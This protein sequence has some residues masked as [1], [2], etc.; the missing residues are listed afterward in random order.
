MEKPWMPGLLDMLQP[1]AKREPASSE[2]DESDEAVSEPAVSSAPDNF[3]DAAR[4]QAE[5]QWTPPTK[6]TVSDRPV[7]SPLSYGSDSGSPSGT[8]AEWARTAKSPLEYEGSTYWN[9]S[10]SDRIIAHA[11]AVTIVVLLAAAL[12]ALSFYYRVQVGQ[13]LVRFGENLSGQPAQQSA[14]ATPS[15]N[16]STVQ[17]ATPP[18]QSA[19]PQQPVSPSPGTSAANPAPTSNAPVADS[20]PSTADADVA[21]K[22]PAGS[23]KTSEGSPTGASDGQAASGPRNRSAESTAAKSGSGIS[24]GAGQSEF[25]IADASL[26]QARTPA[27]KARAAELLWTAVSAGS[28]DAEVELADVYARG[29]GVRKNCQQA[30]ILLAAAQDK[31]NPLAAKES[32][33]LRVYGCR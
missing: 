16:D 33:E 1:P 27:D 3:A 25:Q 29:N 10:W 26:Q 31:N 21:T 5:D 2:A 12:G 18:L 22:S 8:N 4:N 19:L 23:P 20:A 14:I 11:P 6:R 9:E 15:V 17:R 28:S 7:L 24:T 32:A 30:R 13:S